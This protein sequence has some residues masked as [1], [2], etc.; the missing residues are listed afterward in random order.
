ME[1]QKGWSRLS[2]SSMDPMSQENFQLEI[3]LEV[4]RRRAVVGREI[5]MLG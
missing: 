1:I 4:A 3:R 5:F 2:V